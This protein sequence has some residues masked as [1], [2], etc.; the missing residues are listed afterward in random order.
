MGRISWL[1][2]TLLIALTRRHCMGLKRVW[3]SQPTGLLLSYPERSSGKVRCLLQRDVVRLRPELRGVHMVPGVIPKETCAS[4]IDAAEAFALSSGGGWTTKRHIAYP[5]TD[6]PVDDIFGRFSIVHGLVNGHVL[7]ALARCFP[8]LDE[9]SLRIKE[10]FV[11]KFEATEG[12]QRGLGPHKDGTPWSFVL[13]LNDS[14]DY[15]GGGTFF[16]EIP[17]S[18]A[19]I[20]GKPLQSIEA[21]EPALGVLMR[22]PEGT[23]GVGSAVF[24]SGKNRHRGEPVTRGVR[25]ILTGFID[26]NVQPPDGFDPKFDGSAVLDVQVGD[27]LVAVNVEGCDVTIRGLSGEEVMQVLRRA[28]RQEPGREANVELL[29]GVATDASS[30]AERATDDEQRE[31]IVHA[32]WHTLATGNYITLDDCVQGLM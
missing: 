23:T 6:I 3:L 24:F 21:D 26:Y 2:L 28:G 7:P 10:L 25:Y 8:M 5:T 29:L 14:A 22:P 12:K 4:I 27:E 16:E 30:E 15:L 19:T 17:A 9:E 18:R 31:E 11:C 13:C 20:A 1:A 32:K